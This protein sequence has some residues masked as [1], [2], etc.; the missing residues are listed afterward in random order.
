MFYV[1]ESMLSSV[2]FSF[3]LFSRSFLALFPLASFLLPSPVKRLIYTG[4][5]AILLE[6][7]DES[8]FIFLLS[9]FLSPSSILLFF[10]L[11][12]SLVG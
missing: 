6:D 2:L 1:D 3:P 5:L 10:F 7:V 9:P 4:P 8:M 11:F 12:T